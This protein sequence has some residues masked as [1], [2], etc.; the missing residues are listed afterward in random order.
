[1]KKTILLTIITILLSIVN[2]NANNTNA[3]NIV[4]K[5]SIS[6]VVIDFPSTIKVLKSDDNNTHINIRSDKKWLL[7]DIFYKTEN[8]KFILKSKKGVESFDSGKVIIYLVTPT[9]NIDFSTTKHDLFVNTYKYNEL[10][11]NGSKN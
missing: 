7:D 1:M 2:I 3:S 4:I 11:S 5:D 9:E 6:N 8:G 10:T